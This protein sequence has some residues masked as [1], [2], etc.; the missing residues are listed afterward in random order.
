MRPYVGHHTPPRS[1]GRAV[2]A[3]VGR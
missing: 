3:C 2:S 1:N